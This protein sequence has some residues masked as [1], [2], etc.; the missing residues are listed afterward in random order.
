MQHKKLYIDYSGS[1]VKVTQLCMPQ[2]RRVSVG[3]NEL[4]FFQGGNFIPT[5]AEV[6]IKY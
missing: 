5:N 4:G 3:T 1:K 6:G 2:Q